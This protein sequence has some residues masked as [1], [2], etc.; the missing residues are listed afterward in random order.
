MNNYTGR[1]QDARVFETRKL[2]EATTCEGEIVVPVAELLICESEP[3]PKCCAR[4]GVETILAKRLV[5]KDT[6]RKLRESRV[7]KAKSEAKP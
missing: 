6:A 3:P 7:S 2:A 5:K 4:C 1:L